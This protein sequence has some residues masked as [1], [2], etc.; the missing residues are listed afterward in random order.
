[1]GIIH[2]TTSLLFIFMKKRSFTFIIHQ[3]KD[4]SKHATIDKFQDQ[5]PLIWQPEGL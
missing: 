4:L 1:M 3:K 2:E 5:K